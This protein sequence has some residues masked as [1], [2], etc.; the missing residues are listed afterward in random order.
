VITLTFKGEIDGAER[1][2]KVIHANGG[3]PAGTT[4]DLTGYTL[5]LDTL[6]VQGLE[7]TNAT[8]VAKYQTIIAYH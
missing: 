4:V 7:L 5:Y 3:V 2:I 6:N 1:T 8:P